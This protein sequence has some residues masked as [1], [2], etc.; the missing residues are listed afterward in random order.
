MPTVAAY[1]NILTTDTE[2]VLN[3]RGS[4]ALDITISNGSVLLRFAH[5][6]GGMTGGLGLAELHV[7]K[8][9]S[10]SDEAIDQVSVKS[11]APGV[12]ARI[13]VIGTRD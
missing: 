12:P 7:P 3:V 11:G 9:L 4:T 2:Q 5:N 10:I 8:L 6:I 1:N 13:T